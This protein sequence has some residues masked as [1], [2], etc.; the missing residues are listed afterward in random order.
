MVGDWSK[1]FELWARVKDGTGSKFS[2]VIIVV[3][4]RPSRLTSLNNIVVLIENTLEYPTIY[5]TLAL[6]VILQ[7]TSD[8]YW[9]KLTT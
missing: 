8:Y 7:D 4:Y 1:K 5:E 6:S 2:S 3:L 9:Y